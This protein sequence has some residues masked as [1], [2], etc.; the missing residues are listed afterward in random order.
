MGAADGPAAG[1]RPKAVVS[2]SSGKDSAYALAAVR[3]EG[4]L[5]VV[6]LL[7]TVNEAFHRVS[8]HGVREALLDRQADAAGLPV[9]RVVL[10][11]PC[12]NEVYEARMGEGLRALR[13][14]GVGYVIFGDLFLEDIRRY[15]EERMAGTGLRPV[16]PL[17]HRPT[18]RLAREMIEAGM[19]ARVV[20]LDARRLPGRFAGRWFDAAF[21]AEIPPDVDPCGENGEFHTCVLD[22]PMFHEPLRAAPGEVVTRDGFVYVDL[23]PEEPAPPAVTRG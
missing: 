9:R 10:P 21:L 19:R 4:T 1:S 17:W 3:A 14:E 15:R 8:M 13:D 2:W 20:C 22:G 6:G 11:F 16:F 7:T 12:P 23:V 5:D 18:D